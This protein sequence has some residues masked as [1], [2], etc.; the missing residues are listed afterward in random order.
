MKKVL[1]INSLLC[2][3]TYVMPVSANVKEQLTFQVSYEYGGL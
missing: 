3:S 1:L 2:A